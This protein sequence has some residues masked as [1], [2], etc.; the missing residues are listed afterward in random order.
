M[1]SNVFTPY[2]GMFKKQLITVR[3]WSG[4]RKACIPT[5]QT[6]RRVNRMLSVMTIIIK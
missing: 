1:S 6:F 3:S 5:P 4:I 2:S